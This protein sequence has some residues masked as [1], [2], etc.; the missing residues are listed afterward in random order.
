MIQD[1]DGNVYTSILIGEQEWMVENLKTTH[2]NDGGIITD[3][4]WYNN[5]STTKDPWGALYNW[6]SINTNKLAPIGWHIPTDEDFNILIEYLGGIGCGHKLKITGDTCW[7]S[8]TYTGSI[9]IPEGSYISGITENNLNTVTYSIPSGMI[10]YVWNVS[11]GTLSG[12]PPTIVS[13]G[14]V[15]DNFIEVVLYPPNP[16]KTFVDYIFED[17]TTGSTMWYHYTTENSESTNESGFSALP[18]G[19]RRFCG[20]IFYH[21]GNGYYWTS[22]IAPRNETKYIIIHANEYGA[23]NNIIRTQCKW[24]YNQE[25]Y[26]SYGFSVRCVK[27]KI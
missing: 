20:N 18:N 11:G 5:D 14:G 1:Y 26:Q 16:Q 6:E 25:H 19:Y 9:T 3:Y 24:D 12:N 7:T 22:S 23:V 21:G 10:N 27:N 15:N 17:N 2:Y 13:G 8:S 4:W